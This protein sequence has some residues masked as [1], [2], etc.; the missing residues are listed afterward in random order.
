MKGNSIIYIIAISLLQ[1]C[2]G[3]AFEMN[4]SHDYLDEPN[5]HRD[6]PLDRLQ[7]DWIDSYDDILVS[8]HSS[9]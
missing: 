7:S 5:Q 3:M 1:K 8:S 2:N 6:H 9:Q 4:L